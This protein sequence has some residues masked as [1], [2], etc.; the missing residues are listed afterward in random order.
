M[1]PSIGTPREVHQRRFILKTRWQMHLSASLVIQH[2]LHRL[3][4]FTAKHESSDSPI[5]LSFE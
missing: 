1:P 4:R 3:T 2:A 5:E